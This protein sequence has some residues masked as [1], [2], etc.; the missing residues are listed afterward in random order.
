[1][2]PFVTITVAVAAF[3]ARTCRAQC[4]SGA[5][6]DLGTALA[7]HACAKKVTDAMVRDVTD[8]GSSVVDEC[9]GEITSEDGTQVASSFADAQ[10]C[11]CGSAEL[12]VSLTS[13]SALADATDDPDAIERFATNVRVFSEDHCKPGTS[14]GVIDQSAE[15]CSVLSN[16]NATG[17]AYASGRAFGE[18]WCSDVPSRDTAD[19]SRSL[20]WFAS[21]ALGNATA[22][23][24]S[25]TEFACTFVPTVLCV[26]S[27][28]QVDV[29]ARAQV[30]GFVCGRTRDRRGVWVRNGQ[31]FRRRSRGRGIRGRRVHARR[32][33]RSV[34]R[35]VRGYGRSARFARVR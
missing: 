6:S 9:G 34:E 31:L 16:G 20:A 21:R 33:V 15:E 5:L 30:A 3:A 24:V 28:E 7:A 26:L 12:M 14:G 23:S 1:M 4:A 29:V 18:R 25:A 8:A 10:A 27:D 22:E 11:D 32:R 13:R 2:G 19:P 35:T 17:S